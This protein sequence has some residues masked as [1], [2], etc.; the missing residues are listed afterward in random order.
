MSSIKPWKPDCY[1]NHE[2]C[3]FWADKGEC[4]KNSKYM[5]TWCKASCKL[6]K[7]DYRLDLE[8]NDRHEKCLHWAGQGECERNK[9]WMQENCRDAC[10]RCYVGRSEVCI[11]ERKNHY[12]LTGCKSKGCYNENI[13]CSLWALNGECSKN[14]DWMA[15]NCRVSCRI[16][17]LD[18]YE[19]GTCYDY[20][21][22]CREWASKGECKKNNWM[23]E[24]CK[25]SCNS[26][27]DL[28]QLKQALMLTALTLAQNS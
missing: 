21:N 7:T 15:C 26:C 1:N 16:C 17:S 18:I 2:C 11:V 25:S 14:R 23:L 10:D 12:N 3:S 9:F 24:N 19:I 13:C 6:C 27:F 20:H 4:Q 28:D 8:C 5:G 22:Q